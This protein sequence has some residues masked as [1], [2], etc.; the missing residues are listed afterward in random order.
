MRVGHVP[1]ELSQYIWHAIE[2]R[3]ICGVTVLNPNPRPYPLVQV[4]LEVLLD[5]RV[6]LND[7]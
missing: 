5:L 3:A 1:R 2:S 4:R 6:K 7:V